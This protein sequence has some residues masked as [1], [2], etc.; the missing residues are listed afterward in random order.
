MSGYIMTVD[1]GGSKTKITLFDADGSKRNSAKCIG[2]GAANEVE[3]R[4][5]EFQ[6]VFENL[7]DRKAWSNI[8][9]VIINVGGKNIKQVKEVFSTFFPHAHIEAFR[10][11][12]GI[13][14][15]AL[16]DAEGAD[17]I[18]MAGTGTIA[19]AKGVSGNIITDGWCPGV[20]DFGSGYWIGAEAISRSVKALESHLPLSPLAK[21]ITGRD[22]P[23]SAFA[24]TTEQ[25]L[26][27]DK[28]RENFMPPERAKVAALTKIAAE[29]ARNHDTMAETIF[30][31]AGAELADTVLRALNIANAPDGSRILVSGGL[32]GCFDLWGKAFEQKL[33]EENKNYTYFIG[34]ADMTKGALYY[35]Q[36]VM[37]RGM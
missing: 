32:V 7:L 24:D 23:F 21:Y 4:M 35:A 29:C 36:H 5:E 33:K 18:L 11:S 12:S 20:G 8:R 27:R 28:I 1:T 17:A 16:C 9:S 34:D 25:M 6:N 2:I 37:K 22:E 26:L 19:L 13:I 3:I 10:E 31:D 14:M 30:C 15:S